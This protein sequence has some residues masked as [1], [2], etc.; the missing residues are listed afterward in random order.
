M[1]LPPLSIMGRLKDLLRANTRS[2]LQS[3]RLDRFLARLITLLE[4]LRNRI[5]TVEMELEEIE[6]E[7]VLLL[8]AAE[9]TEKQAKEARAQG[10]DEEAES[11]EEQTHHFRRRY[12]AFDEI[13]QRL[14]QQVETLRVKYRELEE[15]RK[16][17]QTRMAP[18][19]DLDAKFDALE[20]EIAE[21]AVE[22]ELQELKKRLEQEK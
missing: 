16:A 6:E 21:N 1:T 19:F 17:A 15:I 12:E 14:K 11:L 8:K 5:R 22:D 7:R 2:L 9:S 13:Y 3:D 20:R 18:D 10:R 4:K